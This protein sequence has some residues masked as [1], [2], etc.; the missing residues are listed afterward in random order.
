MTRAGRIL[1]FLLRPQRASR[2]GGLLGAPATYE[3]PREA[4]NPTDAHQPC[5]GLNSVDVAQSGP[6]DHHRERQSDKGAKT[7]PWHQALEGYGRMSGPGR[8]LPLVGPSR[9]ASPTNVGE[10]ALM[11]KDGQAGNLR[12]H[13][14]HVSIEH[15][16]RRKIHPLTQFSGRAAKQFAVDETLIGDHDDLT[17]RERSS[18]EYQIEQVDLSIPRPSLFP[19][20]DGEELVCE[21]FALRGFKNRIGLK[22]CTGKHPFQQGAWQ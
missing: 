17:R 12:P 1:P 14:H 18:G 15:E 6:M 22:G 5:P 19:I 2:A 4:C 8:I 9:S 7:R 10:A 21:A 3:V 16:L 20:C 11:M 13:E